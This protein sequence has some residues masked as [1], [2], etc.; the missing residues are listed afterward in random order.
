MEITLQSPSKEAF[1]RLS[2]KN[3]KKWLKWREKLSKFK[4]LRSSVGQN[5]V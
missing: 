4:K 1:C 2:L 3:V 5:Y